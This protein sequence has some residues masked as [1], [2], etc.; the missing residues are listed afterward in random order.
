MLKRSFYLAMGDD[1]SEVYRT[2]GAAVRHVGAPTAKA[3]FLC[4]PSMSGGFTADDV[5]GRMARLWWAEDC[6]ARSMKAGYI[7]PSMD[8]VPL[9]Y[10]KHLAEKVDALRDRVPA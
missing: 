5:T 4:I 7:E 1:C 8:G 9:A 6:D 3:I 10:R 2:E